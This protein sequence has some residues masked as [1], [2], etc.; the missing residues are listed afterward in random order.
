MFQPGS[1]KSTT[2]VLVKLQPM[3]S[4]PFNHFFP[5]PLVRKDQSEMSRIDA[6]LPGKRLRCQLS[7]NLMIFESQQHGVCRLAPK[8]AAQSIHVK[9]PGFFQIVYGKGQMKAY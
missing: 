2:R 3:G 9:F 8:R 7:H 4:G 5:L 6:L 1:W